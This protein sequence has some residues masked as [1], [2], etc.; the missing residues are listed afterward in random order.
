MCLLTDF[1]GLGLCKFEAFN[2][3]AILELPIYSF[4]FLVV[5]FAKN[6]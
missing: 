3:T 6:M 1:Q 2:Y 4:I 5:R